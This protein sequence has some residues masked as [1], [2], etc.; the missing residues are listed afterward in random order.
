MAFDLRRTLGA[1][2]VSVV[3]VV[4][5]TVRLA[6]AP[7]PEAKRMATP[8]ERLEL[9]DAVSLAE[10]GWRDE[11][12]QNFPS[13]HWS[14]RD[15]FHGRE[16]RK[17]VELANTKGVRVEDV[18]RAIDDDLHRRRATGPMSPDPRN[19]RAIPCKPRPFYD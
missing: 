14:Q 10:K 15:D 8:A 7:E 12:T 18:L 3:C 19:A 6:K 1:A 2:A 9:A 16:Y 4:V 5:V 17:A 13:D 11:T